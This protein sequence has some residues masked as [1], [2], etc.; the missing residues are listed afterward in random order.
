MKI[1]REDTFEKIK[2]TTTVINPVMGDAVEDHKESKD[3][4]E[5][6]L[7][8]RNY[9][10][11][12]ITGSEKQPEPEDVVEPTINENLNEYVNEQ[13]PVWKQAEEVADDLVELLRAFADIEEGYLS[14]DDMG[15]LG[16]SVDILNDF[17]Q[18]YG[19]AQQKFESLT[20]GS[21][22]TPE[23]EEVFWKLA[24]E[25]MTPDAYQELCKQYNK[26]CD[27]DI[28]NE[29]E[30]NAAWQALEPKRP[31]LEKFTFW[32]K[33]WAELI[34]DD[35]FSSDYTVYKLREIEP[36]NRKI[37]YREGFVDADGNITVNA[38]NEEGLDFAKRVADYYG[39]EYHV[40]HTNRYDNIDSKYR[41]SQQTPWSIT[42]L[43]PEE[44]PEIDKADKIADEVVNSEV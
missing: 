25:K 10:E 31:P 21:K 17:A 13:A 37:R 34:Q 7:K 8:D 41:K 9:L 2:D 16:S 30:G 26:Q 35:S 5:D 24:K 14:D 19:T 44:R 6:V 28:V 23:E 18:M 29:G 12:G 3:N 22:Y 38:S 33:I 11:D 20:E 1:L 36:H 4:M 42:I 39:L 40:G 27:K 43:I 15:T 32:D